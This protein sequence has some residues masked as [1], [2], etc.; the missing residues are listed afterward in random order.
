MYDNLNSHKPLNIGLNYP[1]GSWLSAILI[2][3]KISTQDSNK[4]RLKILNPRTDNGV[5]DIIHGLSY[6]TI[7]GCATHPT[8]ENGSYWNNM[9]LCQEAFAHMFE[10]QFD[11][12]KYN[13]M[14]EFFP[15]ALKEFE[16]M[17]EDYC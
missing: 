14:K 5:S 7:V 8:S 12:L 15:S 4:I 1:L 10:A 11:E 9:S 2:L 13:R 17:L 16:T 6:E 3:L